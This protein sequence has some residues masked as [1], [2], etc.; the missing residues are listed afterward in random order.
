MCRIASLWKREQRIEITRQLLKT[1]QAD[2]QTGKKNK[3]TNNRDEEMQLY[4]SRTGNEARETNYE[5]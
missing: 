3:Q 4:F 2:P 5:N 1:N